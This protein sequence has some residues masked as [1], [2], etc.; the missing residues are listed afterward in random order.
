[1]K[2]EVATEPPMDLF[3]NLFDST[4]TTAPRSSNKAVSLS[5][6]HCGGPGSVMGMLQVCCAYGFRFTSH[7][8]N[9]ELTFS[10]SDW[11]LHVSIHGTSLSFLLQNFLT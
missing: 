1:M 7:F 2:K 5:L 8:G 4:M 10:Y 11:W 9:F 3:H 6:K